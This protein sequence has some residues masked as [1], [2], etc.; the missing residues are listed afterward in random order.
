MPSIRVNV[1]VD[2]EDVLEEAD[3]KDLINELHRRNKAD[4]DRFVRNELSRGLSAWD[5]EELKAAVLADDGRRV[6]DILAPVLLPSRT[7]PS[8]EQFAKL[9]RD[10]A[11]GRPVIQ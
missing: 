1:D 7:G 9:A 11:T 6:V 8:V 4:G 10:P 5:V 2:I 3:T